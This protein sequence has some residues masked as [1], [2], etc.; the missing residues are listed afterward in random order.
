MS[1]NSWTIIVSSVC[2]LS[3]KCLYDMQDNTPVS[4]SSSYSV[5]CHN[6]NRIAWENVLIDD[7][8]RDWWSVTSSRASSKE[9]MMRW[10]VGRFPLC[11]SKTKESIQW[12][13]W[14]PKICL[15]SNSWNAITMAA[16]CRGLCGQVAVCNLANDFFHYRIPGADFFLHREFGAVI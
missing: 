2:M 11:C 15:F 7:W 14:W 9:T 8:H 1:I 10:S 5:G 16:W 4:S 13:N 6:F 3:A 12:D